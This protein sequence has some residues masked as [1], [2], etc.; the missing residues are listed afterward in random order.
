MLTYCVLTMLENKL[1]GFEPITASSDQSA[2]PFASGILSERTRIAA[3]ELAQQGVRYVLEKGSRDISK[4]E[5]PAPGGVLGGWTFE[6]EQAAFHLNWTPA[7]S[8]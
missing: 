8:V 4:P 1:V 2:V 6:R 7:R 5:E 3:P